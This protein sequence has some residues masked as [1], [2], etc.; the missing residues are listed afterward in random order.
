MNSNSL[1]RISSAS[2]PSFTRLSHYTL[3][4]IIIFDSD[5]RA[6]V[7]RSITHK[8]AILLHFLKPQHLLWCLKLNH[9]PTSF[10][11]VSEQ[12]RLAAWPLTTIL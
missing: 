11:K 7:E 6:A 2:D 10:F 4:F 1:A 5:L 3:L 12:R 9:L 8:Q